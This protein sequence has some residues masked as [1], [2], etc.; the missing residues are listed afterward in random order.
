MH[1][2]L[3]LMYI[4]EWQCEV[5]IWLLLAYGNPMVR[6]CKCNDETY[7]FVTLSCSKT[8][9]HWPTVIQVLISEFS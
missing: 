2:Y 8:L 7:S 3:L 6:F 9:Y 4:L 5:A 1:E